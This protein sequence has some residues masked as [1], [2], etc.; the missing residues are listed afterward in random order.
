MA[1]TFTII[2]DG[3]THTFTL[4]EGVGPR[5]AAGPN[6]V[7]ETTN[8][9]LSGYLTGNGAT[10][11]VAGNSAALALVSGTNT[12]DQDLS[13][14]A[15]GAE[16]TA[17]ASARAAADS[18]LQTGLEAELDGKPTLAALTCA[19]I[20]SKTGARTEY[21]ASAN[22][23]TARGVA[24]TL[25]IKA[26][27]TGQTLVCAPGDYYMAETNLLLVENV[28]Y[29]WNGARLYINGSSAGR[30]G[31]EAALA[32]ALFTSGNAVAPLAVSG[33]KF[34]GPLTL[35]GGSVSGKRGMF[36]IGTGEVLVHA[37]TFK[38]WA[39]IGFCPL[40]STAR[41][42]RMSDCNFTGNG[43]GANWAAAEYWVVSNC[44]AWLNATGFDVGAGNIY[45]SNCTANFNSAYGVKIMDGS[46]EGHGSWTGGSINHHQ[47]G[48]IGLYVDPALNLYG[49][50][51]TGVHSYSS[52]FDLNGIGIDWNGGQM[53]DCTF[54]S[55]GTQLGVNWFR[56]VRF[57]QN[58]GTEATALAALTAAKRAN[59][60]FENCKTDANA[61]VAWNDVVDHAYV[62]KTANYTLTGADRT[63][64]VTANSPTITLPDATY[65]AGRQYV[66]A[67]TGAGTV[68]MATTSS[69]TIDGASPGTIATTAR[70]RVESNGANW[71]TW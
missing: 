10:V 30:V 4:T 66:I 13:G 54:V 62:A 7:S 67:N 32:V 48:A 8:T 53:R 56:D 64:N 49:F 17:E 59:I 28:T 57:Y 63:V 5:G 41:G 31:G 45:F 46:N 18:A 16:L 47:S 25:A 6:N 39:D 52:S 44:H 3:Q 60:K 71:I 19:T 34:V 40:T 58:T 42:N 9:S 61:Y 43:K 14:Y 15:T 50:T 27:T 35:D 68:T 11:A 55:S 26:V 69:Q 70:L 22:T 36:P 24:L 21:I 33:W 2:Q 12:G 29:L 1:S 20:I 37:V 38:N 65:C 51:F 23:D